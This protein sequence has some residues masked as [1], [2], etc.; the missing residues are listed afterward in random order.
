[1]TTSS[2]DLFD[3]LKPIWEAVEKLGFDDTGIDM[4]AFMDK[5]W[6]ETGETNFGVGFEKIEL[7]Q[8]DERFA[9]DPSAQLKMI[10]DA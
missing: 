2:S 4:K 1:M 9:L 8:H 10:S 6:D 3:L 7:T 5:M